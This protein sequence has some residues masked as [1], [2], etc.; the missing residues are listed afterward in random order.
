MQHSQDGLFQNLAEINWQVL[1]FTAPPP[2]PGPRLAGLPGVPAGQHGAQ[3]PPHAAAGDPS[4]DR[5]LPGAAGRLRREGRL[6]DEQL[7]QRHGPAAGE[8]AG[9]ERHRWT[10]QVGS[11]DHGGQ[12]NED[13]RMCVFKNVP[14]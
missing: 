4:T 5:P 1:T 11:G 2:E 6:Q 9:G 7:L 12:H 14:S 3:L 10:L 13:T 8:A